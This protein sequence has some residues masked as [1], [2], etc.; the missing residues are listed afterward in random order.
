MIDLRPARPE[1]TRRLSTRHSRAVAL[2]D[3]AMIIGLGDSPRARRRCAI[4]VQG[5]LDVLD[6]A[7]PTSA[8]AV[9]AVSVILAR[10]GDCRRC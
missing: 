5:A 6:E 8:A 3:A 9:D 7:A 10:C 4:T 1:Q 2:A